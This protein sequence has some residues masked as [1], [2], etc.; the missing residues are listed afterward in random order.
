MSDEPTEGLG[1]RDLLKRGALVG[2]ALV[3]TVPAVQTLASP[4]FAVGTTVNDT[5]DAEICVTSSATAPCVP[6]CLD[7]VQQACCTAIDN[8]N[9]EPDPVLRFIAYLNAL[10]GPCAGGTPTTCTP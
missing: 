3:W 5:C 10:T 2:G 7:N 4:A 6:V 8:A 9:A 1:R